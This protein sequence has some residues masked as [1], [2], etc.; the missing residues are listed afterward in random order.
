MSEKTKFIAE[1]RLD[2][3]KIVVSLQANG[4]QCRPTTMSKQVLYVNNAK[5]MERMAKTVF[6]SSAEGEKGIRLLS[7]SF[8]L[9]H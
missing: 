1:K 2:F 7:Q 3:G 4:N 9:L 6:L 5:A 8:I